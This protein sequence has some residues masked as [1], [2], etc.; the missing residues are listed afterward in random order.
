MRWYLVHDWP[1][2]MSFVRSR[3]VSASQTLIDRLSFG[4]PI[5]YEI[6]P[7]LHQKPVA[8]VSNAL[9]AFVTQGI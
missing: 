9:Y 3:E 4:L 1:G 5:Y 7:Q 8:W 6:H 2:E